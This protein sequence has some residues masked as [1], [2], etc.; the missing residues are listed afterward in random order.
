MSTLNVASPMAAMGLTSPSGSGVLRSSPGAPGNAADTYAANAATQ[1]D[2]AGS[3]ATSAEANRAR[4]HNYLAAD[5]EDR[6]AQSL[7]QAA[8]FHQAGAAAAAQEASIASVRAAN[9][10]GNTYTSTLAM[11]SS[12]VMDM[13]GVPVFAPASTRY[14][15]PEMVSPLRP[16]SPSKTAL[17]S[18]LYHREQAGEHERAAEREKTVGNFSLASLREEQASLQYKRASDLDLAWGNATGARI[19]SE[20]AASAGSRAVLSRDRAVSS[21]MGDT[22]PDSRQREDLAASHQRDADLA[23]QQGCNYAAATKSDQ[24]AEAFRD[25]AR[26]NEVTGHYAAQQKNLF[27]AEASTRKAALHREMARSS[28]SPTS[29]T[30][31]Q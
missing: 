10:R 14:T 29:K 26:V 7:Q 23:A 1:R 19:N 25:A 13:R 12:P 15:L 31:F 3:Y 11:P 16:G 2:I 24:A 8:A 9:Y 17:D 5:E 6:A 30:L 22:S 28:L 20:H 21:V 18:S 4:G 27:D